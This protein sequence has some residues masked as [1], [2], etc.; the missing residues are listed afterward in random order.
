ME[1]LKAYKL[2]KTRQFPRK[3]F[4]T[5]S[6]GACHTYFYESDAPREF[7][8]SSGKYRFECWGAQ[9]KNGTSSGNVAGSGGYTSGELVLL[10]PTVF[11]IYIGGSPPSLYN[12]GYNGG[13]YAQEGGGGATDIRLVKGSWDDFNSLK[14][15]IMVAAGGGGPDSLDKGGHAGG[16]IGGDSEGGYGK[17]GTQT[18]GGQSGDVG[19]FGKGGGMQE[20]GGGGGGYYGG[21][22]SRNSNDYGGGGGSSFISGYIGCDAIKE[23]STSFDNILHTGLPYHYS[24]YVFRN[25]TMFNGSSRMPSPYG[26]YSIGNQKHGAV[27]ITFL[28]FIKL[29]KTRLIYIRLNLFLSHFILSSKK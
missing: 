10:K 6:V 29:T 16:L 3:V 1:I 15:R 24:G 4:D 17:G 21:G 9:G 12:K 19:K 2:F 7:S 20:N 13:G 14:S 25:M 8:F 5:S 22:S 18:K 11:Y 26:G 27:R 28:G 23:S